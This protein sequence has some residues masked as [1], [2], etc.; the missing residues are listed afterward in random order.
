MTAPGNGNRPEVPAEGGLVAEVANMTAAQFAEHQ[1]EVFEAVAPDRDMEVSVG[2]TLLDVD[3][4]TVR[5][6]GLV[7]L[8]SVSFGIRRGEILGLI[9]PNGAGKTTCFNAMTGVY[10]PTSGQVRLE[11]RPLAKASRHAITQLG[12]A[13]TFQNIRLFGEMTA[14]EN[15]VV[16]T[17]A[18]HR[19]SLLGALLR[20]PRHHREEKQAIDRAMALLEFVGIADRAADRAKNLPYGYQRRLEIA[21]A[22]ATEPKLLCLDEPAAG[23]NPAEKEELMGLIRTIRDD[24]YTV[25]LIEHDMKLVMGVTD[26]IVVLEFGKKIAEGLPAQIREDPAVIAAY[27]GVPDDDVA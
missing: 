26:R 16:G 4:V 19:T 22:L 18:R 17:D 20:S 11:G 3:D 23:F 7:A 21:R 5:F 24:G 14:L 13:R 12:I 15:V 8:D 9:G 6:G 27:L 10:R 1:T 25:L 2:Q